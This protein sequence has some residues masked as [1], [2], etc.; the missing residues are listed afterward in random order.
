MSGHPSGDTVPS[1]ASDHPSTGRDGRAA[2]RGSALILF[3]GVMA[4][5][6]I[7][8]VAVVTL[9]ANA[10]HS[11]SREKA[12]TTAFDVAEA[13]IDVGMHLLAD[14]WPGS[15]ETAWAADELTQR[16]SAFMTQ[17]GV[18]AGIDHDGS[19][20]LLLLDD[21]GDD[22]MVADSW[23]SNGNGY[24]WVDAQ[25]RVNGVSSRIRA[26]VKAD[27]FQ[28]GL[29]KGIVLFAGGELDSNGLDENHYMIGAGDVTVGGPQPVSIAIRDTDPPWDPSVAAPYVDQDPPYVPTRN[30]LLSD[31]A[32]ADLKLLAQRDN[33][34]YTQVPASPSAYEGLCVIEVP[35][36]TTVRMPEFSDSPSRDF[37]SVTNP[38][39]LLV[40]GGGNLE[41]KGQLEYYGVIYC[42]GSIG[43][44]AGNPIIYGMVIAEHDVTVAGGPQIIYREDC[45]T[46][47]DAQFETSTQLVPNYWRELSPLSPSP[48]PTP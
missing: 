44:A 5:L 33:S 46:R 19:V 3:M 11:T 30:E 34:Y 41:L 22:P 32:I 7:M 15:E 48:S 47:L 27:F 37:N 38:G 16:E 4:A 12:R 36:G 6:V 28:F 13:A 18:T 17:F 9:L 10:Q 2:S 45:L 29:A 35:E 31:D 26:M 40:L 1:Q 8:A 42:S 43:F 39:V 23:D 14:E 21:T 25:A 20:Q 24:V